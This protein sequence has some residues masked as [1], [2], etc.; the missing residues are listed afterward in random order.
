MWKIGN[1]TLVER[2]W[3]STWNVSHCFASIPIYVFFCNN[4]WE[5]SLSLARLDYFM[6]VYRMEIRWIHI[7]WEIDSHWWR[8][9][10]IEIRFFSMQSLVLSHLD[11]I[12]NWCVN[13][14][15]GRHA[16]L[17]CSVIGLEDYTVNQAKLFRRRIFMIAKN[18]VFFLYKNFF[19][20]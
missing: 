15:A 3:T 2:C 10:C 18:C 13:T 4:N 12:T 20:E 17:E 6:V 11:A 19:L 1:S 16:T 14:T 5:H 8:W 9:R 7:Y